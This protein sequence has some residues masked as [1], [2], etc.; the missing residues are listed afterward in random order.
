MHH[1]NPKSFAT[2][3]WNENPNHAANGVPICERHHT[4]KGYPTEAPIDWRSEYVD[5]VHPDMVW[6]RRR[7][8]QEKDKAFK[9]VFKGRREQREKHATYWNTD[10]DNYLRRVAQD[11]ADWTVNNFEPFP[12]GKGFEAKRLTDYWEGTLE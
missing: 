7:Y 9:K 6:A 2:E 11:F 12:E 4:G 5:V 10:F 8:T 3:V 1:V